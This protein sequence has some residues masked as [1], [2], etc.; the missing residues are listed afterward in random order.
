MSFSEWKQHLS[1]PP[2]GNRMVY[3]TYDGKQI[4]FYNV[5]NGVIRF[6]HN[7]RGRIFNGSEFEAKREIIQKWITKL[8]EER[9]IAIN[10]MSNLMVRSQIYENP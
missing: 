4:G 2:D 3:L 7:P 6:S 10:T 9:E 5:I 8:E 1:T